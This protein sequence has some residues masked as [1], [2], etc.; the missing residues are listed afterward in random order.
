MVSLASHLGVGLW[1]A[2]ELVTKPESFHKQGMVWAGLAAQES[3]RKC[4][5][6]PVLL[7]TQRPGQGMGRNI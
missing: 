3:S 1:A 5:K 4:V 2:L 6:M 7:P